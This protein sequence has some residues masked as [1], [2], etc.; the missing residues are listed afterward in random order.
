MDIEKLNVETRNQM[1]ELFSSILLEHK[2][3]NKI[4]HSKE[5]DFSN[6]ENA[7]KSYERNKG[8]ESFF[9][10]ISSGYGNGPFTQLID[11]S[12][13]YDLIGAMGP[14]LLG[15]SHPLYIKSNLEAA[16]LDVITCGNLLNYNEPLRLTEE[17]LKSVKNT[18]LKHFWFAGSGSFANDS[19]LKMIWQNKAPKYK[20][21]AFNKAFAGR[22]IAT[23][24]ITFNP[25]YREN[26][27][28]TLE[29]CHVPHFDQ[30]D[31][32]NSLNKTLSAL[33][34]VWEQE[35]HSI[36]AMMIELIQG[37][38]GFVYGTKS[39]YKE[40][41]KWAK[42]KSL[43]IWVDEVQTF[44]RTREIFA[45]QMFELDEYVDVVT[46]GKALQVCG[47]LYSEELNPKPGLIAGT[48]NGALSAIIAGQKIVNYLRKG[49]FYG[50]NGRIHQI[51]TNFLS[52]L[53]KLSETTCKGKI[54]YYGG[55]G[56]MISFEVGDSSKE[57]TIYFIKKLYENGVISFIAGNNPTRVRF[58]LP[59]S[60]TDDHIKEI[61]SIV[62]ETTLDLF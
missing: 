44:G 23:Q 59:L 31:P 50:E 19:A 54:N 39:F 53:K 27:P 20:V 6:M 38:A 51:E 32:E 3:I 61:F 45:F 29:V 9:P 34:K 35:S 2:K 58:L 18:K 1:N 43:F 14:N 10:Y 48:F 60:L 57:S 17:I 30:N 42:E 8:R 12:V 11:G 55:I 21:I 33:E 16:A 56:T 15:H 62:E 46:V 25:S 52:S 24:D 41:F 49:P 5:E 37:E 40:I 7:L 26:M 13:K 4:K 22:S 28:K 36:C 47:T